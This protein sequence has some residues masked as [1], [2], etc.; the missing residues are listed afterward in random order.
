MENKIQVNFSAIDRVLEDNIIENTQKEIKGQEMI[1]YGDRNIYPNYIYD[2]YENVSVVKSVIDKISKCFNNIS[3]SK[4][5]FKVSVNEQGDTI[6]DVVRQAIKD[7]LIYGGFALNIVR[8]RLGGIAG[9]YNLD[10]KNIRSNKKNTVFYYSEKWADKSLGRIKMLTYPAFD[11]LDK[12][13]ATS[14]YYFKNDRYRTYPSPEWGGAVKSAECLKHIGEFHL[15]SLYNGLSSDYIVNMNAGVPVDE[16]KQEI[17]SA[18]DEKYTGFQNGGR[19]MI[20]WNPDIQ[21]RCTIEAIPQNS[22]IDRYN[23]LEKSS[24][25]DIYCAFGI[26]PAILG[27]PS[28]NIGFSDNDIQESWK[29]ANELVFK[30]I[31]KIVKQSFE[32]IYGEKE[33]ITIE[34]MNINWS[35]NENKEIVK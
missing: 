30:P 35:E 25:Q 16:V 5:E 10:F 29:L 32:K 15:N 18:F 33:V 7:Y 20:S 2:L 13:Q 6:E 23:A 24:K 21:H 17:E 3:I 8:N 27:L 22:F 26:S 1:Q 11:P 4:D 14:I 9:I 12:N 19:T 34:M 31:L 28:E